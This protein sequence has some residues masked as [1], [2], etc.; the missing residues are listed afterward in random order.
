MKSRNIIFLYGLVI[1]L[2]LTLVG[3]LSAKNTTDVA[4]SLIYLPLVFYFATRL[5]HF[6]PKTKKKKARPTLNPVKA[7]AI[8]PEE[9]VIRVNDNDRRLFL[10]LIASAG[11]SMFLMAIFTKK[12]QA[13]FFGS[14]PTGP[15]VVAIKNTAGVE[16]D[17]AQAQPTDGYTISELD[18]TGNPAYYGFV[19]SSGAWYIMSEDS[20]GAYR[21]SKGDTDFAT[22]WT[23]RTGLTYD[24]F[25]TVFG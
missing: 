22:N 12:A 13:A 25:N 5:F 20:S 19:K 18:D 14:A 23:N 4:G 16:I 2:V 17:P 8:A 6:G 1:C 7:V 10:K 15:G 9:G 24:Y 21:Y 11:F 3:I